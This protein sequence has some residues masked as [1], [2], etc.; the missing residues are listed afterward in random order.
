MDELLK[1]LLGAAGVSGYEQEVARIVHA[2]FTAAGARAEI[3]A[4]GNVYGRKGAGR[5]KI[6]LAAHLDEIGLVVKHITKEGYVNF[7]KVGGIDDRIL[8]GQRVVIKNKQGDAAGVIGLKPPHLMKDEERKKTIEY[9][10]LFIDIGSA[11]REAAQQR[12]A[13]GDPVIFEPNAGVLH[14]TVCYGKAVDDRVGCYVL[15][16][17]LEQ[18]SSLDAEVTAVATVQEEVGLKGART[19]AFKIA[20][21]F[22]LVFDTTSAGDTPLIKE[23]ESALK[24]GNGASITLMEAGGRG[25]LVTEKMRAFLIETAQQE[26]IKY[27]LDIL[28]GGMTDGAMI[29]LTRE[30]ILTGVLSIPARYAHSPSGVFDRRDVQA[31]IDLA[32]AAIKRFSQRQTW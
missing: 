20:P 24:I 2:G 6:L 12:I 14:E 19:A 18:L 3:D 28:E 25:L 7:I 10:D 23:Q 22:A 31:V 29:S 30:G 1:Q 15:I 27:Q 5:K 13:V 4:F 32:V 17:I 21:D 11:S 16:K 26:N 8:V 9:T